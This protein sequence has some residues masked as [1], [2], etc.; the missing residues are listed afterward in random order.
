MGNAIAGWI[1]QLIEFIIQLMRDTIMNN[2]EGI[3]DST[4]NQIHSIASLVGQSPDEMFGGAVFNII[5]NI[6][7][8]IIEP[9]GM[10]ILAYVII[11]EYIHMII[12]KNNMKDFDTF[13][14]LKWIFKSGASIWVVS[15]VFTI[16][17]AIFDVTGSLV[18]GTANL[19]ST[20]TTD[21]AEM[22]GNFQAILDS[23]PWGEVIAMFFM[24]P[25]LNIA[26]HVM[27][28]CIFI[29][30]MGRSFQIFMMLS[31][32]PVPFATFMNQQLQSVGINYSKKLL[33]IGLQGVLMLVCIAIYSALLGGMVMSDGQLMA[34]MAYLMGYTVLLILGLFKTGSLADSMLGV[35]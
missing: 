12:D 33:A 13:A 3:F 6:A 17:L 10:L 35:S 24:S 23:A 18:M 2:L 27:S 31:L 32:A 30:V 15:N 5:E 25:L 21:A 4:N 8:N 19:V 16:A 34:Q 26:M 7:S 14:I 28:I 22:L 1:N 11:F 29:I 9:L 20:N